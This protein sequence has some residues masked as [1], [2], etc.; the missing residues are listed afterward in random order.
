MGLK[1]EKV[2]PRSEGVDPSRVGSD[3]LYVLRGD[4]Y[5]MFTKA[6]WDNLSTARARL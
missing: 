6:D 5:V 1:Q 4:Q 2:Q 3:Q